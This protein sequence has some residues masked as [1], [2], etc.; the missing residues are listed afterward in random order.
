MKVPREKGKPGKGNYWTLDPN[1]EDM[2]EK[3]NYRRRKRRAKM[4]YKPGEDSGLDVDCGGEEPGYRP[5]EEG[6]S[7]PEVR[8]VI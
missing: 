1:C 8:Y 6:Q 7:S 5:G 4:P 2:F 3:G